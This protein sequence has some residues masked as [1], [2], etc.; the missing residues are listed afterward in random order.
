[1]G[2]LQ[3]AVLLSLGFAIA[4]ASCE[5]YIDGHG[6]NLADQKPQEKI[7]KPTAKTR[8]DPATLQAGMIWPSD[9]R[10]PSWRRAAQSAMNAT[11]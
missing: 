11:M 8:R 7:P 3:P 4:Q 9:R 6:T 1:V 5:T 2:S 10:S